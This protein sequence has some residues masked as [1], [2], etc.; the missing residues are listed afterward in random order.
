[1]ISQWGVHHHHMTHSHSQSL[2]WLVWQYVSNNKVIFLRF[3]TLS[4]QYKP[5]N[6]LKIWLQKHSTVHEDATTFDK[7]LHVELLTAETS[8]LGSV[9]R[10][11][12]PSDHLSQLGCDPR[13]FWHRCQ[14]DRQSHSDKLVPSWLSSLVLTKSNTFITKQWSTTQEDQRRRK[15]AIQKEC[16]R[17]FHDSQ[18]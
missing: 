11:P 13:S 5:E 2:W 17:V 1:M 10:S 3:M 4:T 9:P 15:S 18:H 6:M 12:S 7:R 8:K 16:Q 14:R